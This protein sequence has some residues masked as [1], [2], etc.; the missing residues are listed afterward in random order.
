MLQSVELQRVR[1][2]LMTEQQQLK[3]N[4]Q[5]LLQLLE[6]KYPEMYL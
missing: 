4:V 2:N 1:H 3:N 5:S 6:E